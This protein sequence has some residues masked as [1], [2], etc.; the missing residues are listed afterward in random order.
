MEWLQE[1]VF[2]LSQ[3]S[4]N[5]ALERQSQLTKPAGAL[6]ELESIAVRLSAM[7]ATVFPKLENCWIS[8]F[9]A[10]HGLAESGVSAFPQAVTAQ[11][12]KNFLNKGAAISVLAEHHQARLEIID[13][14]V[15]AEFAVHSDLVSSKIADGTENILHQPA[16]TVGQF[17]K[18]LDAGKNAAER[19]KEKGVD[20]LICGEMGIGNTAIASLLLSV[21]LKQPVE[22]LTGPGTGLDEQGMLHKADIL[23]Q[24]VSRHQACITSNDPLEILRCL[25]G[26]EVVALTGAFIRSAQIGLPVLVDGVIATTAALMAERI[27]PTS[28]DWWFFAHQSAE[29]AHLAALEALKAKP[30]LNLGMRLGEGSGAAVAYPL[31]QQACSL[32]NKM[33]TFA[34]A[35]ISEK[36]ANES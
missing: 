31:L 1:P 11:M 5:L 23:K 10:D 21:I 28:Q 6:G 36:S 2:P 20:I 14:G 9:A 33:S 7:Q 13:V 18:A 15:K 4:C 22:N 35:Q 32:H 8:I 17:E 12:V 24:V 19:A 30:L 3:Q 34:E 26:F 29:P 27:A 16:M 25:G